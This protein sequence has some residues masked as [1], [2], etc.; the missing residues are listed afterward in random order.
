MKLLRNLSLCLLLILSF[1]ACKKNEQNETVVINAL[2]LEDVNFNGYENYDFNCKI[3]E[4]T[5]DFQVIRT[6]QGKFSTLILQ[7][8]CAD[9]SFELPVAANE[10]IQI[11]FTG[12]E[13]NWF[14]NENR[15]D[16]YQHD[17]LELYCNMEART[18]KETYFLGTIY[19][20]MMN[21]KNKLFVS[22]RLFQPDRTYQ[23]QIELDYSFSNG[24]DERLA[25]DNS[26]ILNLQN[27][28]RRNFY[29]GYK[30]EEEFD[31]E[32]NFYRYKDKDTGSLYELSE[33]CQIYYLTYTKEPL[34]E[35]NDMFPFVYVKISETELR[36]RLYYYEVSNLYSCN[37]KD[38]KIVFMLNIYMS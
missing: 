30:V 27:A 22:K 23:Q 36:S 24:L 15:G 9:Q 11:Y 17:Y 4:L 18:E 34:T 19:L 21:Y 8:D 10:E 16:E 35:E 20:D 37:I 12:A 33:D 6:N 13:L 1:T 28:D 38:G 2:E 7:S 3:G 32:F 31:E 29:F 25:V 14:C 26:L 5:E